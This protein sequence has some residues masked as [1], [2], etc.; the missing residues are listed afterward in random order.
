VGEKMKKVGGPAVSDLP[1]RW[2]RKYQLV[3]RNFV[4]L[5]LGEE[6][7]PYPLQFNGLK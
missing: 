3:V 1:L 6:H 2:G 4:L 7:A 5:F